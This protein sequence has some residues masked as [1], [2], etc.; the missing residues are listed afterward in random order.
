VFDDFAPKL[1]ASYHVIGITRRG[2]GAS[3]FSPVDR[4]SRFA[5]DVLAV[6]DTLKLTR[7]FIAGHSIAG[8][9]VSALGAAHPERIAG[10]IYI[11]AGYPYAFRTREGP[12]MKEFMDANGASPAT[13]S[14]YYWA[15]FELVSG[16]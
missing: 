1:V 7:A 16:R 14:P 5:D 15:G 9:E 13:A 3:T 6:M 8:A 11:E 10:L 4:V 12:T 2:F